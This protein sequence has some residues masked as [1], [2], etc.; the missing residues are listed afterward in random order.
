MFTNK[1]YPYEDIGFHYIIRHCQCISWLS[2]WYRYR[3]EFAIRT[4]SRL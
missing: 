2:I 1:C 3:P 4:H